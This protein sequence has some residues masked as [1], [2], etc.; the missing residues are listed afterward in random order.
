MELPP[1]RSLKDINPELANISQESYQQ[2]LFQL[3]VDA[4]AIQ[5]AYYRQKRRAIILFEGSDAAGKGGN[6]GRLTEKMDPRGFKVH[7]IGS[8]YPQE[9]AKH[10]LYR[11]WQKLPGPGTLAIF[12]RSWYGRVLVERVK[13]LCPQEAWQ[14]AYEEINAF[15]KLLQ[16]DGVRIVKIFLH[17]TKEEQLQRLKKRFND[18]LKVWKLTVDDFEN[19]IQWDQYA[20]A[21]DE[22][23][24][25]TG[26]VVQ[27]NIV[28]ANRKKPTRI[29]VLETI[30]H[31]LSE[32]VDITPP[33]VSPEVRSIAERVLNNSD[34]T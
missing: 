16:D 21:I 17:I 31:A 10:Y 22:M 6:I 34:Q 8:P 14:R 4:M 7:M 9:Q 20:E 29:K 15:E 13:G 1:L 23:L 19:H 30:T 27:W 5:R 26:E 2:S 25:R 28:G 18:P 24:K 32:G 33:Q 3:Q 12:D 11:F